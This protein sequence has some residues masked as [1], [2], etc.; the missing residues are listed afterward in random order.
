MRT[1]RADV[2]GTCARHACHC[3]ALTRLLACS[4]RSVDRDVADERIQAIHLIANPDKLN[5][6]A[7][8]DWTTL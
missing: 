4:W 8:I 3:T 2:A 5:G 6:L 7:E 1:C